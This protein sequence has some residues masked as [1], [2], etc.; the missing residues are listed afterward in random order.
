MF[1][2]VIN[3]R[4]KVSLSIPQYSQELF[5]LTDK[6]RDF[7]KQW[8]PWLDHVTSVLDTKNFILT[9]L[10][11]FKESKALHLTIFHDGKIAGVLGFNTIDNSNKIG[12]I[13]YWLA[14]EYNG[15]GIMTA[16]VKDLIEIGKDFYQ[17]QK[18]DIRC[19]T[20]NHKSK[21]IPEKLGFELE[22]CLKKAEKVSENWF[23][24]HVYAYFPTQ[25]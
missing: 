7:L 21:A 3:E 25:V 5:E 17:L 6:N 14:E 10:E 22:A 18:I 16:C 12:Y 1:Y 11:N 23:D 24:H 20:K 13:G 2:R 15:K 4:T 19:A 8:L 9:Q